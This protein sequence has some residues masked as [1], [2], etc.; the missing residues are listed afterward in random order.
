MFFTAHP[1]VKVFISHGGLI[2]TQEAIFYGVPVIGVP[3]YGDQYNNLLQAEQI[4]F[5]KILEF[6]HICEENLETALNEVLTNDSYRIK[7]KDISVIFKD[8]P[9]SALDTAMFWIEYVIRHNGANYIKSPARDF[10]WIVYTML[11]VYGAV[12]IFCIV[13]GYVI[14]KSIL[15][16]INIIRKIKINNKKLDWTIIAKQIVIFKIAI[17][18]FVT[19]ESLSILDITFK[20]KDVINQIC[21]RSYH[22]WFQDYSQRY[23]FLMKLLRVNFF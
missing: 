9:L 2:G 20:D 8:R 3:I 21:R 22:T 18:G 12:F 7:A 10:N 13:F 5:G 14:L 19:F 11:D 4:G 17:C 15:F 1:N 23:R 16:V 6:H